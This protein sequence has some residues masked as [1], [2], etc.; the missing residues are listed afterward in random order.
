METYIQ[1]KQIPEHIKRIKLDVGLSYGAP[2]SNMWLDKE[3]DLFVFGFE[4]NPDCLEILNAGNIVNQQPFHPESIKNEYLEKYI[5]IIPVALSNVETPTTMNFYSMLND[6]GTSSLHQPIDPFIG[7]P[8]KMVQVP[9]YSLKHFF[10]V[11]P[12]DRFEYIEYIKI[13]AQGSDFD[14]IKSA[15]DYL[16]DRVVYI[17]AEPEMWQYANCTHN[18]QENMRDYLETQGF[19]QIGHPNVADPTF[20]NKKYY[21]LKDEIYIMQRY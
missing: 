11:F 20:I 15:G 1:Q 21:H 2:F 18:S 7:P 4:P 17:T 13:D 3:K 16:K 12:W 14:I 9:V 5:N 8:K 10:D 19:V 6:C